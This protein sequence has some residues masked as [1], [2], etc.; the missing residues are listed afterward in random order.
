[1]VEEVEDA[2]CGNYDED[3]NEDGNGG[4]E[5]APTAAASAV[6]AAAGLGAVARAGGSS[7]RLRLS[8]G[9]CRGSGVAVRRGLAGG[10]NS[11]GHGL[12]ERESV[13][14]FCES[15]ERESGREGAK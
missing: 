13:C 5:A 4:P 6:A 9:E 12:R 14:V 15:A 1:M 2:G 11:V 3:Q 10:E 7:V 8:R